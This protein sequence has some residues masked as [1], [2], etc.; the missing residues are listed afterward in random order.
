MTDY[1][2]DNRARKW[3]KEGRGKGSGKATAP[4][5]LSEIYPPRAAHTE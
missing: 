3:I 5:S 1:K 4:G 2:L